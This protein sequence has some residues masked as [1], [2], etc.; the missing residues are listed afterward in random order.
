MIGAVRVLQ[1]IKQNVYEL[2]CRKGYEYRFLMKPTGILAVVYMLAVSAILRANYY[3]HDDIQR[4]C[5]GWPNWGFSRHV[6]N[7]LSKFLHAG[8]YLTDISPLP[9][10]LAVLV[11]ALASVLCIYLITGKKRSPYGS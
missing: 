4:A 8:S 5:W 9:Q 11:I 3:Y 2:V 1:R 10:I 7:L 6:S